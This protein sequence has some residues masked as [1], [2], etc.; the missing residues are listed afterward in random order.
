[1]SEPL[2]LVEK[3]QAV[4]TILINRPHARNAVNRDTADA[5]V[6][7]FLRFEADTSQAVAVLAGNGG[8]F[9]AGADL[10]AVSTGVA[11][12]MESVKGEDLDASGPMG[13]SRLLLSKPVIAAIEGFAVAGGLE[14]ACWA[15]MR[16]MAEDAQCGVF[17][18]RWG[19]PLIDGGTV[20]LPR[21]I[22]HSR[23]LDLV[24]TGRAVDAAE[25]ERIGLANRVVA[26]GQAL[27]AAQALAQDI[28]CFPQDCL[29]ADR[30]SIFA[31]E[32]E[33]I[34]DAMH[35]EFERGRKV[36][37][38]GAAA[39]GADRFANGK[40]RGGDFSDI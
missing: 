4:T 24:L 37:E 11:N 38:S 1:M 16:V 15:D 35:Q 6:D 32:G 14:L 20:R 21:L 30:Y 40:G 13:P 8:Y 3:N 27:V 9:C 36:V 2:V 19:V 25:A 22:G 39:A 18:R 26:P 31:Q 23:A 29:R 17:C 7:A 12:R 28:A 5:L 10:K 33:T 34:H